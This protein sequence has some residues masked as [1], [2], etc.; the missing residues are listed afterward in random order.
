MGYDPQN[1]TIKARL[2]INP[3][4]QETNSAK[5]FYIF[6]VVIDLSSCDGGLILIRAEYSVNPFNSKTISQKFNNSS[7]YQPESLGSVL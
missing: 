3:F 2:L 1:I 7:I 6:M 5:L 4:S